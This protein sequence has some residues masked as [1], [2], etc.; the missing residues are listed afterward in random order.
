MEIEKNVSNGKLGVFA[1]IGFQTC[2]N[3]GNIRL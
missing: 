2:L 3:L 1:F